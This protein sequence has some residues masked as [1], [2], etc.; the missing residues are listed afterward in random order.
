MLPRFLILAA[1]LGSRLR[2]LTD[3]CPKALM[4]VGGV[5]LLDHWFDCIER[6]AGGQAEVRINA[7]HLHEQIAQRVGLYRQR[8]SSRWTVCREPALL[9]TAGT[10]REQLAWLD[11]PP[12]S[13]L[14]YADNFSSIDLQA[15]WRAHVRRGAP[16]T[17]ALFRSETPQACGLV[18]M[19][20]DSVIAFQ[21][22]PRRPKSNL[23]NA[24]VLAFQAGAIGPEIRA[25][26]RDL[27]RDLLPR[28]A[29]R[30]AGWILE[31]FHCDIGTETGLLQARRTAQAL[32]Q[33]APRRGAP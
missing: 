13:I 11:A 12:G 8:T 18:E 22:K 10:V 21:E 24:G 20:G 1:G 6:F 31:D 7:H 9:G 33:R 14:I 29:G 5:P 15:F 28:F 27:G 17:M 19:Q 16:L 30:A 26:D 4:E 32:A 3:A 2:P 25:D 23:A